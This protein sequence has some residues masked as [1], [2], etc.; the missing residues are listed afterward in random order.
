M[1][2]HKTIKNHAKKTRRNHRTL[3]PPLPGTKGD[4][5]WKT[6]WQP[7]MASSKD[8]GRPMPR[9]VLGNDRI[10]KPF[11]G[12]SCLFLIHLYSSLFI[13]YFCWF[14]IYIWVNFVFMYWWWNSNW[15]A[16]KEAVRTADAAAS[17][18]PTIPIIHN[19]HT[20][21]FADFF[22]HFAS[23]PYISKSELKP[24]IR[25][26][27]RS[28]TFHS[29][30]GMAPRPQ[31]TWIQ[32][33][34]RLPPPVRWLRR[35]SGAQQL[36]ARPSLVTLFWFDSWNNMIYCILKHRYGSVSK[37][38]TPFV[39]IKIAGKWMFIPLKMVLIGIDPYPYMK[40]QFKKQKTYK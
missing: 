8:P 11:W 5:A 37:P 10:L 25:S 32:D 38:C 1:I 33:D 17:P 16:L 3:G 34:P 20:Q 18:L 35:A 13:S 31:L 2:C 12:L 21:N 9:V 24:V 29:I 6:P 36:Q 30:S 7:L 19:L 26:T 14:G 40:Q 4:A 23:F 39:H 22:S 15:P 27:F 28:T